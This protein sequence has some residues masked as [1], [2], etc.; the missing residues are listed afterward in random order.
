MKRY[1]LTE[2][3]P[4]GALGAWHAIHLESHGGA[5]FVVVLLDDHVPAPKDWIELPHLL[6]SRTAPTHSSLAP[7]N[8]PALASGFELAMHLGTIHQGFKP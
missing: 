5:G 4:C 2:A 1:F 7:L 6:D 3:A 8:A